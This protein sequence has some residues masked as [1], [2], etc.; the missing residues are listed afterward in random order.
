[1]GNKNFK[2]INFVFFMLILFSV[3][4]YAQDENN[5]VNKKSIINSKKSTSDTNGFDRQANLFVLKCAGCHTIGGGGLTG[6]DLSKSSKFPYEDL[7]KAIK[8]ME[9]KVGP[10]EE[11][12][13]K[14]HAGFIKAEDAKERIKQEFERQSKLSEAK[15]DPPNAEIGKHLFFGHRS[16]KNNGLSCISCHSVSEHT[17]LGGG[18][19]GPHLEGL[20]KNYSKHNLA[21]AIENANW[22]IMKDVYKDH[23]ITK[24]EALHLVAYL[25]SIK[26]KQIKESSSLF[27]IIGLVGCLFLFGV[28]AFL[29]RNKLTDVHKKVRRR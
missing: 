27:H 8:R 19:L 25:S 15:L 21:S 29:Y 23:P 11:S 16:L 13:I 17:L 7:V 1:M 22:K 5:S 6:P 12:E 28:T 26:D 10:M 18:K 9:E 2:I 4:S 14:G 3:C 24:Q 20:F